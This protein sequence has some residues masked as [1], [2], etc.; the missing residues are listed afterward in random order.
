MAAG[1]PAAAIR[2]R[3]KRSHRARTIRIGT[4]SGVREALARSHHRV[5]DFFKKVDRNGDGQVTKAEFRA[6]LPL[7]GLRGDASSVLAI[8]ALFDS[9]DVDGN[10]ALTYDE[11]RTV[12]RYE[13]T[14]LEV[15]QEE[16]DEAGNDA[17]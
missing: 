5:I 11:L 4:V 1:R 12:L 8:D 14:R 15:E 17:P 3:G 2:R 10:G 16:L 6:G 9:F 13:A 7:L